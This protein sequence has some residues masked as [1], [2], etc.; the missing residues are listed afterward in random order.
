M[1]KTIRMI[2]KILA[3]GLLFLMVVILAAPIKG[4]ISIFNKSA[5]WRFI[6]Y[7]SQGTGIY[8]RYALG[9]R[10]TILKKENIPAKNGFLVVANHLGYIELFSILSIVPVVFVAKEEVK[11]WPVIGWATRIGGEVFVDRY[12]GGRS[13]EYAGMV[14]DALRSRINVFFAPEG[15]TSD[16][17]FIRRFKSP[18]FVPANRLKRCVLPISFTV[19]KIN[20]EIVSAANRDLVAWH[21]EMTFMPHFINFLKLKSIECIADINT[22]ISPEFDDDDIS[23]RRKFSAAVREVISYSYKSLNRDYR[24]DFVPPDPDYIA[25]KHQ[26]RQNGNGD[27]E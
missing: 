15:T 7:V 27:E 11:R 17:T 1:V 19:S 22:P 4:L 10:L 25:K 5:A 9:I 23:E 8:L 2:R 6:F 20:G 13:E 16:G 21:S 3:M 18:L 14:Y 26:D 12:T 24:E